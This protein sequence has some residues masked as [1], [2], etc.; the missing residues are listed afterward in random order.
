MPK[1]G[2]G[3][4]KTS[5]KD[6]PKK[7]RRHAAAVLDWKKERCFMKKNYYFAFITMALC[8]VF[9]L[10]SIDSFAQTK[11]KPV[12]RRTTVKKTTVVKKPAVKLYAVATGEKLHV[13]MSDTLESKTSKVGDTFK[14]TV[15]EP[16]YS[17]TGAMLI[18][19]GSTVVGKV[20]SVQRAQK[21]GKPGTIDVSFYKLVIPN[22]VTRTINGSLTELDEKGAKSDA[23]GTVSGKKM[24]HRKIIFIG[25]GGAG[26]AV[27]GGLIGGTKG[28]IIGGIIGAAGGFGGEKL[29]K[30]PEVEVKAGTEFG[31]YL[32]QGISLPKF[33]EVE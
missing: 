29:T 11:R 9:M 30:G 4:G 33:V 25:G 13:R 16:V 1:R 3:L 6:F 12:L 31:V 15:L 14:A 24:A 26:G 32:N 5:R 8:A 7:L 21:G 22:G 20:D 23:E 17:N 10:G 18:P 19:V 2:V 27:L 28:A